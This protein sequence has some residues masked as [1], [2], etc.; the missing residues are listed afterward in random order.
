MT[1]MKQLPFSHRERW[2]GEEQEMSNL[3]LCVIEYLVVYF[4]S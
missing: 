1:V 4:V 2:M 3:G